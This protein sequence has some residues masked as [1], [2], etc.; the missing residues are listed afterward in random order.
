MVSSKFYSDDQIKQV[1]DSIVK[2]IKYRYPD[3]YRTLIEVPDKRYKRGKRFTWKVVNESGGRRT[4]S[5]RKELLKRLI[6]DVG[7]NE[8]FTMPEAL[9]YLYFFMLMRNPF[10]RNK[11]LHI[12]KKRFIKNYGD[13]STYM[14]DFRSNYKSCKYFSWIIRLILALGIGKG[15]DIYYDYEAV[16]GL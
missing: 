2:R 14:E 10:L 4:S 16:N 8:K 6:S 1:F 15:T 7:N 5:E 12:V 9:G 3:G 11:G 13:H